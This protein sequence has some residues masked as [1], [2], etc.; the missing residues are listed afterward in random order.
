MLSSI[1]RNIELI[2]KKHDAE[3]YAVLSGKMTLFLNP[4]FSDDVEGEIPV[5]PKLVDFHHPGFDT[6]IY[7]NVNLPIST[8]DDSRNPEM[9]LR[10]G[11]PVF[12]SAPRLACRL[13][14]KE[15]PELI[16][17]LISGIPLNRLKLFI[18]TFM[19]RVPA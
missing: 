16:E 13:R 19:K 12:E 15:S 6:D 11:A 9:R 8:L 10:L 17:N 3:I 14:F 1:L 5:S 18:K 4:S 2:W 7:G